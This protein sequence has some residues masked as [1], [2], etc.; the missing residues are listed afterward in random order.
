MMD[1]RQLRPGCFTHLTLRR[2]SLRIIFCAR[3]TGF[4]MSA[5]SVFF[6]S[7]ALNS[8]SLCLTM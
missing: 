2:T 3:L 7:K 5:L 6:L 4:W 8:L 1:F